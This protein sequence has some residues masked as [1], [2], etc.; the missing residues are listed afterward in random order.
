[1]AG[2]G[3]GL[4]ADVKQA[5]RTLVKIEK[6]Y[7]P[8]MENRKVYENAYKTWET[9]YPSLLKLSDEGITKHMWRAP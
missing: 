7:S 2:K 9:A 8:N 3:I 1:M 6:T 4:F 5:A